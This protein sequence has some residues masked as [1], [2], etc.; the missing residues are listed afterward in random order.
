[1]KHSVQRDTNFSVLHRAQILYLV[2]N[3]S[4]L[5]AKSKNLSVFVNK[6]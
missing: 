2:F 5:K 6:H 3:L 4:I 1:M